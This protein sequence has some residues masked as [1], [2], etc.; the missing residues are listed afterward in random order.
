MHWSREAQEQGQ[1]WTRLWG[2]A[3][4]RLQLSRPF[5]GGWCFTWEASQLTHSPP[6][7]ESPGLG[8]AASETKKTGTD[9][10]D[11]GKLGSRKKNLSLEKSSELNSSR[12]DMCLPEKNLIEIIE[13]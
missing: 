13:E 2:T 6:P 7:D 12:G 10:G 8:V 4:P 3:S 11:L 9:R 5:C 1:T